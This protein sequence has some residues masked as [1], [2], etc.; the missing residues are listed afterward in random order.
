MPIV[1]ATCD[2]DA[3]KLLPV[4]TAAVAMVLMPSA[5]ALMPD[6]IALESSSAFNTSPNT[7]V[8]PVAS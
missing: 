4:S 7:D 2:M 1:A 8:F 3:S 6:F 5:I